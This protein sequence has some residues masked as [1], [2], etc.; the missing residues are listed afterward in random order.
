LLK[1]LSTGA[2]AATLLIIGL[3]SPIPAH[4]ETQRV[5]GPFIFQNTSDGNEYSWGSIQA[6][7]GVGN[8]TVE[9]SPTKP[10]GKNVVSF[11][12]KAL[13]SHGPIRGVG[14]AI[15]GVGGAEAFCLTENQGAPY[16]WQICNGGH[17]QDF[18]WAQSNFAGQEA[19]KVGSWI[20]KSTQSSFFF[21]EENPLKPTQAE[22]Y[23]NIIDDSLLGAPLTA[24]IDGVNHEEKSATISGSA[25]F[26]GATVTATTPA[27]AVDFTVSAEGRWGGTVTGLIEGENEVPVT[28][29]INGVTWPPVQ[30]M[31]I[32]DPLHT[33]I[34]DPTFVAAAALVLLIT[35]GVVVLRRRATARRV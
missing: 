21:G 31:I 17:T 11:P 35:A 12:T 3:F 34:A 24:T 1:K 13:G 7:T 29:T 22:S 30:L 27:G 16:T 15:H 10:A 23:A 28:Q 33:P 20:L 2:C 32:V 4:A 9:Y 8:V 5:E 14:A 26:P 19:R 18:V 6:P 25:G